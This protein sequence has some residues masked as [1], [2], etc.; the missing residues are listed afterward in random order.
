[1]GKIGLHSP[2]V[3]DKTSLKSSVF[4]HVFVLFTLYLKGLACLSAPS[5]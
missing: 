2:T 1:M 3:V 5:K 4:S